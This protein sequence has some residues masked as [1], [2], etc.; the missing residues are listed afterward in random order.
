MCC[1]YQCP[2]DP[3]RPWELC[4]AC[5]ADRLL[6]ESEEHELDLLAADVAARAVASDDQWWAAVL[7]G[8]IPAPAEGEAAA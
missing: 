1:R 6:A 2:T 4:P 8:E 5:L 3:R 7:A